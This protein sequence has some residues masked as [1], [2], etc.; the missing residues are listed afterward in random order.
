YDLSSGKIQWHWTWPFA[1]APLRAVSSPVLCRNDLLLASCGDGGGDRDSVALA[2]PTTAQNRSQSGPSLLW[3]LRR[4]V[5]Y[6]TC[7]LQH[8]QHVYYVAD[9]GVAGCLELKTGKDVWQQRLNGNF[10]SS[11]ILIDVRIIVI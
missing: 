7:L 1:K 6:V 8:E 4:D 3:Q 5:P 11:P 9:K 10:T 2:L